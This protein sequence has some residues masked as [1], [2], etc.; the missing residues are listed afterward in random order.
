MIRIITSYMPREINDYE[1]FV[2]W[3]MICKTTWQP[4]ANGFFND[5]MQQ[6]VESAEARNKASFYNI[7]IVQ[8]FH[9]ARQ[10]A[11]VYQVCCYVKRI[12]DTLRTI[13]NYDVTTIRVPALN[14]DYDRTVIHL[15]PSQIEVLNR[16]AS[17]I[18]SHYGWHVKLGIGSTGLFPMPVKLNATVPKNYVLLVST[19]SKLFFKQVKDSF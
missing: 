1:D 11:A 13:K 18:T 15:T 7:P 9:R 16:V 3:H 4:L 5:Y 19:D 17:Y 2:S 14:Q 10:L 12:L 6:F 8:S